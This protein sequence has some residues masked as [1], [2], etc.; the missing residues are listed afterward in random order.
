VWYVY[1]MFLIAG[2][3]VE[4]GKIA[5][6]CPFKTDNSATALLILTLGLLANLKRLYFE[7]QEYTPR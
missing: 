7:I 4:L 1:T 6:T 2:P 3:Q 5:L